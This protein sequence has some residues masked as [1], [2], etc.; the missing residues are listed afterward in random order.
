MGLLSSLLLFPVMGPIRGIL[1]VVEQIQA[2]AEA[3]MFDERRIQAQIIELSQRL[4][5]GEMSEEEY[6]EHETVLLEQ[7]NAI[8]EYKESL[9]QAERYYMEDAVYYDVDSN[10]E[11]S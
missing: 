9:L 7:L 4:D 1:F 6:E 2:E 3:A 5:L 11:D 8:I 10:H